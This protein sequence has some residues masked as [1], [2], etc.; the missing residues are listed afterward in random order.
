MEKITIDDFLGGRVRL[1][2]FQVGYRA[3]SDSV[4]VSASVPVRMG[5]TVLDVGAGTGVIGMCLN[6]RCPNLKITALEIQPELIDLGCENAV[7]NGAD[8]QFISGDVSKGVPELIG[9]QFHHVVTNPPFY[10]EEFSR[11]NPQSAIAFSQKCSLKRW[12]DFCLRHLR[13]KGSFC[14]IH[15]TES[16]PEILSVLNGRLGAIEVFPIE[17]KQGISSKRIVVRG[18]MN[19][20]APFVLRSPLVMHETDNS[21]TS[22]AE[23]IMRFG[24]TY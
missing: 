13:A 11:L 23:G 22:F 1:K 14:M 12:I 9:I 5:Q 16:L 8:M 19:S 2:Q 18:I 7:L 20:K 10:T 24:K 3:T 21:R 17:P 15:R 4:L 6:A